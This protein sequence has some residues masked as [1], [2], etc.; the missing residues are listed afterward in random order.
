MG[1]DS[2]NFQGVLFG[3][4]IDAG[5]V[6]ALRTRNHDYCIG[7]DERDEMAT[8]IQKAFIKFLKAKYKPKLPKAF[9]KMEFKIVYTE[10][11]ATYEVQTNCNPELIVGFDP[12]SFVKKPENF[13]S[14]GKVRINF[15]FPPNFFDIYTE[16]LAEFAKN[17]KLKAKNCEN[18]SV[19]GI[20]TEKDKYAFSY[21]IH[22]YLL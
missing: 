2:I 21:G 6:F 17:Q 11:L 12:K 10:L 20:I 16:F 8:K 18:L 19:S 9:A 15:E 14:I 1:C 5:K 22:G 7:M 13:N 3:F 4:S